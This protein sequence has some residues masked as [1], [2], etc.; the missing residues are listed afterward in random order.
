MVDLRN[1]IVK[2]DVLDCILTVHKEGGGKEVQ[3]KGFCA[4]ESSEKLKLPNH[5]YI[6]AY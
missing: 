3:K 5:C 4:H 1:G 2:F 6:C